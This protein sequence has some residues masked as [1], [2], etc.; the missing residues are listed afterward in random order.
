M[1][2]VPSFNENEWKAIFGGDEEESEEVEEQEQRTVRR[3]VDGQG[4][5]HTTSQQ[6]YSLPPSVL[7]SPPVFRKCS[8]GR[9]IFHKTKEN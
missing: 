2:A 8:T 6:R 7:A 4:T 5:Q 9:R 3:Q 1:D